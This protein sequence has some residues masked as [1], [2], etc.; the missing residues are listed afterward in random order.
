MK[1]NHRKIL[2]AL[3]IMI[4]LII[5]S[6]SLDS[7]VGEDMA[8]IENIAAHVIGDNGGPT[9]E[10]VPQEEAVGLGSIINDMALSP[11]GVEFNDHT[12][13]HSLYGE[14][15]CE[16]MDASRMQRA[17]AAPTR[18]SDDEQSTSFMDYQNGSLLSPNGEQ[19]SGALDM[20]TIVASSDLV[21]WYKLELTDVDPRANS[22]GGVYNVSLTL[23]RYARADGSVGDLYELSLV[24][25]G[26]GGSTLA[27]DYADYLSIS[28]LYVDEWGGESYMGG[29]DLLFDDGDDGDG[30][31]WDG[32][33]GLY[34]GDNWT[35]N[36]VTPDSSRLVE[37]AEVD[38]YYIGISWGYYISS[39]APPT[40][41]PFELEYDL[42]VDTSLRQDNDDQ[43]N[44]MSNARLEA[45]PVSGKV[46]SMYDQVDWVKVQG[47]D[48][49][50]LWNMTITVRRDRTFI[51][52]SGGAWWGD[53]W[54][55][56]FIIWRGPGEDGAFNT[57]DDEWLHAHRILSYYL[58]GGIFVGG[59]FQTFEGI[60]E[61]TWTDAAPPERQVYIG[62]LGEAVDIEVQD[63]A[64]T[65]VYSRYNTW[66]SISEYTI[67]VSIIEEQPNSPP[68][69]IDMTVSSDHEQSEA[70]GH[71]G[72][73][74]EISVTYVDE[75][76]D[77]PG[78]VYL[79][80]DPAISIDILNVTGIDY[81]DD[82]FDTN[83]QDG[84]VYRVTITGEEI[85]DDPGIHDILAH[86]VDST[87]EG[88][89]RR[90]MRSLNLYLNDTLEV[91]DDLPISRVQYQVIPSMAE[92]SSPVEVQLMELAGE[93]LF[94]DPEND[95]S[96]YRI[97]NSTQEAWDGTSDTGLLH[98][99]IRDGDWNSYVVITPKEGRHGEEQIGIKAYDEHSWAD[100]NYTVTVTPV[101][102]VPV[103]DHILFQGDEFEVDRRGTY[104]VLC[105]LSDLD[106]ME[107][108]E[109]SFQIVAHDTDIE[110]DRSDLEFLSGRGGNDHWEGV[111]AVDRAIGE[112][113]FAPT[114]HD[115]G[116]SQPMSIFLTIQEEGGQHVIDLEVL[117][118]VLNVND[119]PVISIPTIT[120]RT[121]DQFMTARIRPEVVDI[122]QGEILTYSVNIEGPLGEDLEPLSDQLPY[123]DLIEGVDYTFDVGNGNLVLNLDDQKIW[124]TAVGWTD[125]VEVTIRIQVEDHEGATDH[126]DITLI[127]FDV[128]EPHPE[129]AV[130]DL[131]LLDTEE[132]MR[133]KQ[134]AEYNFR[135]DPLVD[136]D[137]DTLSYSWNFG[138]GAYGE[139]LDVNHTYVVSG[140]YQVTVT[141]SDGDSEFDTVTSTTLTVEIPPLI[142][143]PPD[144]EGIPIAYIIGAII[145]VVLIIAI[146]IGFILTW[147]KD[148]EAG[149][150]QAAA[151][152]NI[153]GAPRY[154]KLPMSEPN[155]LGPAASGNTLPPAVIANNVPERSGPACGHCGAH[156]EE[157]WFLC[158][159]CKSPL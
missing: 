42:T 12:A 107:D 153:G 57:L 111:V 150:D 141:V 65:G 134:S 92:D 135:T 35:L 113:T 139:G 31:V 27:E 44:D 78:G 45:P 19:V 93:G 106:I 24:D 156:V 63:D 55:N 101:N 34:P 62:L 28:I 71:L 58:V 53:N 110:P 41:P 77:P 126:S 7:T 75:D 4:S 21:D 36:F 142:P 123:A 66:R 29:G 127:L 115:A 133:E 87:Q 5:S 118:S 30:W 40:R 59:E 61:N 109:Y 102:D 50:M 96:G 37:S 23:D 56:V 46:D 22:P 143:D 54:M 18:A 74:F 11:E 8:D 146:I 32:D 88:S 52:P 39:S 121:Y 149:D 130:I 43:S 1:E 89:I 79:H 128:E 49:D 120:Q 98:L 140:T 154:D 33:N 64:W 108:V 85:G 91:W 68:E 144:S 157:G 137:G 86:A 13:G 155:N 103:V 116:S 9:L 17:L 82:P 38:F 136:P 117:V 47:T 25:D 148:P 20:K 145:A 151:Y 83:Y 152:Q 6:Q 81:Q 159:N 147:K 122:D 84:K 69:M 72:S 90:P 60:L 2:L 15:E 70:G 67:E 97:W 76:N 158:P 51:G 114:N 129:P 125:Q 73:T 138:D 131:E 16:R 80:L 132:E 105:D 48:P 10:R 100:G 14:L 104:S 3:S 94:N 26:S 99:E 95:I 112:V 124:K 119:P